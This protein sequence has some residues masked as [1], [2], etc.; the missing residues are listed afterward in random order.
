MLMPRTDKHATYESVWIL[1]LDRF[2]IHPRTYDLFADALV[3]VGISGDILSAARSQVEAEGGSFDIM[4]WLEQ[5]FNSKAEK[6][7]QLFMNMVRQKGVEYIRMEGATQ[8][9]EYLKSYNIPFLIMTYGGERYQNM[10]L[11]AANLKNT[12]HSIVDTKRK[13]NLIAEWRQSNGCFMVEKLDAATAEHIILCDD[14]AD[15]F[16][17]YPDDQIG[18]WLRQTSL[19]SQYG[20]VGANIMQVHD[21]KS[22]V[23]DQ[24]NSIKKK[25]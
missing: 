17:G 9:L 19:K 2:L 16:I 12:P 7:A 8:L 3:Q 21:L 6:V 10:K 5:E 22:I 18:Y 13:G 23:D 20:A 15:A 4:S 24:I 1:D 25:V 11:D 14:K